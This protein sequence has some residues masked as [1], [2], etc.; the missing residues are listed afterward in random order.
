MILI[1]MRL[2]L[3]LAMAE[4][5]PSQVL[6]NINRLATGTKETQKEAAQFLSLCPYREAID[7]LINA[8]EREMNRPAQNNRRVTSKQLIDAPF[9]Q[10]LVKSLAKLHSKAY[11][12]EIIQKFDGAE[13]AYKDTVLYQQL[14]KDMEFLI[15]AFSSSP[16]EHL[17]ADVPR[18]GQETRGVQVKEQQQPFKIGDGG[19]KPKKGKALELGEGGKILE[20]PQ[21]KLHRPKTPDEISEAL[22]TFRENLEAETLE[23][24]ELIDALVSLRRDQLVFS[25][26]AARSHVMVI[27]GSEAAGGTGLIQNYVDLLYEEAGASVDQMLTLPV[28]RDVKADGWQVFGSA[29]GFVGSENLPPLLR[30]LAERSGSRYLVAKAPTGTRT[31]FFIVKNPAYGTNQTSQWPNALT[32]EMAVIFAPNFESWSRDGKDLVLMDALKTGRWKINNPGSGEAS[33]E[34][35]ALIILSTTEGSELLT[36][37]NPDG[38]TFGAPLNYEERLK[39][40]HEVQGNKRY[41]KS[42]LVAGSRTSR[43]GEPAK[44]I[45]EALLQLIPDDSVFLKRPLSPQ[46]LQ[47][48]AQKQLARLKKFYASTNSA[49]G[50]FNVEFD[51]KVSEFIRDDNYDAESNAASVSGKIRSFIELPLKRAVADGH[52]HGGTGAD[53]QVYVELAANDD[54][55]IRFQVTAQNL[56]TQAIVATYDE[57]V[58]ESLARKKRTPLTEEDLTRIRG[59]EEHLNSNVFGVGELA[60]RM[61]EAYLD[62]EQKLRVDPKAR[63]AEGAQISAY[64]GLSSVGK[65]ETANVLAEYQEGDNADETRIDFSNV[66]NSDQLKELIYGSYDSYGNPVPSKFMQLYDRKNGVVS[67]LFDELGNLP[68]HLLLQL[69]DI[70]RVANVNGFVDHKQRDMTGVQI[71]LTGNIGQEIF[72]SVPKDLPR[73]VR[74]FAMERLYRD[75]MASP[76]LQRRAL[77]D[78]LPSALINRI[79][80]PNIYWYGPLNFRSLRQLSQLKFDKMIK[81]L[82][83]NEGKMGWNMALENPAQYWKWIEAIEEEGFVLDEQGASIDRF[84][85]QILRQKIESSL[86]NNRVPS[87]S[88][89]LMR[90]RVDLDQQTDSIESLT[91]KIGFELIIPATGQSLVFHIAGAPQV[92]VPLHAN[93]SKFIVDVHESGHELLKHVLFKTEQRTRYLSSLPGVRQING[94]MVAY[95]GIAESS[96][97]VKTNLTAPQIINR[98]AVLLGGLEA[99]RLV[100]EGSMLDAGQSHDLQEA[101]RLIE[102]AIV[103]FGLDPQWGFVTKESGT[104]EVEKFVAALPD[105]EKLRLKKLKREWLAKGQLVARAF[106]KANLHGVLLPLANKLAEHGELFEKDF[107]EFYRHVELVTPQMPSIGWSRLKN[108][109]SEWGERL[110]S[111]FSPL[112]FAHEQKL[113]KSIQPPE[114]MKSL[115]ELVAETRTRD[116]ADLQPLASTPFAAMSASA[117]CEP[118]LR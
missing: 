102:Y 14:K 82:K 88:D 27:M 110:V 61:T 75:F 45:S 92:R 49:F 51:P 10:I 66:T 105:R 94:Q 34:V 32:P 21:R 15:N 12:E 85:G 3:S 113:I 78:H 99:Q 98:V 74:M 33:I 91:N 22:R 97:E 71:R 50:K 20:P 24:P 90:R 18:E 4:P 86:V 83:P 36:S 60:T 43:P 111:Q 59:L 106:L 28:V 107:E 76:G 68:K 46:A 48:I 11:A 25:N 56:A 112:D 6:H 70:F 53:H 13:D 80:L 57:T 77:E 23:Q 55:T 38:T 93:S 9:V 109:I 1:V 96:T 40:W 117:A 72:F 108:S 100:T 87:G 64:F 67:V 114:K 7:A 81:A 65:T 58:P 16:L 37:R 89:V 29:T 73:A 5:T 52:L 103:V 79:G 84:V 54:G 95:E 19:A 42:V 63:K 101:N 35:P 31:E 115:N 8:L 44:G 47:A 2:F 116:V 41:L 39:K 17:F 69:Y 62:R 104:T 118:L 30:Y 26:S